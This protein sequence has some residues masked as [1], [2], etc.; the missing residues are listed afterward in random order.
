MGDVAQ[1]LGI[2]LNQSHIGT[3]RS[4]SS[5]QKTAAAPSSIMTSRTPFT[6]PVLR[7]VASIKS[8][9]EE[10]S[11]PLPPMA[12]SLVR[13]NQKYISTKK[14]ARPWCWAPFSSEARNDGL[15]LHHWVRAGVEYPEYPFA[16]FNIHLDTL[17]YRRDE[18]DEGNE[19]YKEF[20]QDD[21]WTK[22]ETDVLL[23]FCRIYELR[24]PVI[25][26]RWIG[27]FGSLSNKKV[28][29]LQHRYYTI[30]MILN[31]KLV[32]KAAKVEAEDLAKALAASQSSRGGVVGKGILSSSAGGGGGGGSGDA[33]SKNDQHSQLKIQ[34]AIM[35]DIATSSSSAV[36]TMIGNVNASMQPP[37]QA[38]N[39]GTTNQPPFDLEA[40]RQRRRILE[41]IWNRSKEEELEEES[42]RAE[43][44]LVEAQIRKLK[45]SGGHILAA[46]TAG[47]VP[48]VMVGSSGPTPASSRGPS[49]VPGSVSAVAAGSGGGIG[50]VSA[51]AGGVDA[52]F[53]L[54]DAQFTATAP[55]PTPGIPYLQSGRLV[56]PAT[57]GHMSISKASLKRMEQILKE[58][59][60]NDR[61]LPTK[62]VCDMY[63]HVRKGALTLLT[64][65]KAM[66]KKES[67]VMTR[68]NKLEKI[69]G[70]AVAREIQIKAEAAKAAAAAA[71][72]KERIAAEKA[73]A[74]EK[75]KEAATKK[76]QAPP[77]KAAANRKKPPAEKG[78]KR[79]TASKKNSSSNNNSNNV[80]TTPGGDAATTP[81]STNI[82]VKTSTSK[83]SNSKN[84]TSK[85]SS[86]KPSTAKTTTAKTATAKNST[87]KT[88]TA[89][90]STTAKPALPVPA[91]PPPL[92]AAPPSSDADDISNP[93]KR[94]KLS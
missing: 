77:K 19:F 43:L 16:R 53:T 56:N 63:D 18:N 21:N 93:K 78:T 37:I 20:L 80:K 60:V 9:S 1:I 69:A 70:A 81:P 30:G 22:S 11:A 67:E 51:V 84:S 7:M 76:Q 28:E 74:K 54:L 64:L 31:R 58:L 92:T 13:V 14:K 6:K 88:A 71:A 55:V 83:S 62:R 65:Q 82:N 34:H 59:K 27:R 23:D 4:G 8:S 40:E 50:G 29:D 24:W 36:S 75:A 12:P 38:T 61:P 10:S 57:G 66:L 85:P 35:T 79:K 39:T 3:D 41:R 17:D 48:A 68:R 73:K 87:S 5:S 86:S 2:K 90:I 25:I 94:A 52:S 32:E 42:L 33:M 72:E 45:K 26:D 47:V 91:N 46:A 89:K 44:K 49:P 15:V